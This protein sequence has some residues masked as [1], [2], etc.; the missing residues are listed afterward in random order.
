[1]NRRQLLLAIGAGL[2]SL[3]LP[4]NAAPNPR[5]VVM[6]IGGAGCNL[7]VALRGSNALNQ[8][9]AVLEYVCV[10]LGENALQS[11]DADPVLRP[12]KTLKLAPFGAGGRVNAARAAALRQREVLHGLVA[13]ASMVM[14]IAGLGGGTGSGITPIM[15][16]MA[17][18]AGAK[19]IAAVVTPFDYEGGRNEK[20]ARAIGYL[21]READLVMA[22]SNSEWASR[23]P[24][25]TPMMDVF[26]G[27]ERHVAEQ[28]RVVLSGVKSPAA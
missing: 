14:L 5:I 27:L 21:Q 20:A 8:A 10:D 2:A 18:N 13:D 12:I 4:T 24:Y 25:D 26:T 23:Y 3:S 22:T 6:G 16:R 15:A 19:T 17:R 11:V 28:L 9:G 1:M 7:V